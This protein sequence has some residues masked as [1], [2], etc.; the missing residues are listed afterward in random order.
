MLVYYNNNI[1][2]YLGGFIL[3]KKKA[4][5]VL[6]A[7]AIAASAFV[8]TAP[9]GADAAA[10][11]VQTLVK[12]AKDAGTVLKWAIS[13]E[14]SADGKTRPYAQY[15]AAKAARD[16]AVKAINKLPASQKA[17]YLADIEQN[18]TLHIN[19]TMAYIDAIT[20][21]EKITVKKQALEAQ[22]EKNLIDDATEKAYHELSTEIRKQAIL[23]DRVYGQSTRDEIRAQYKKSAEAVRDSVK[24]EVSVKIELDLAKKALAANNIADVEKHLAAAGEYMKEV[25]NEAMKAALTKALEEVEAQLTPAVK[26]VAALNAKQIEV[27][28]NS[29]L[30]AD[31]ALTGDATE[32]SLY[33]LDN[34]AATS[35]KLSDDKKSVILTFAAGIEGKDKVV[36][37]NP[38]LTTKKDKDGKFVETEKHSQIFTYTDEVKPEVTS[39]TYENGKIIVTY[40]EQIGTKPSVVRVNGT[41]VS[42]SDV[43]IAT[44]DSTKVEITYAGLQAGASASLYIAGTKDKATVANEAAL[45]NG[46]VVAPVAD[47]A[48]P[49]VTNVEVTGQNTA[50]ITLSKAIS[51]ASL[52]AKLQQGATQ[53]NVTLVKDTNDSTG[54][55]YTL[56]VDINGGTAGDG[57]FAGTSTTEAFVLYIAAN[58]MTDSS[59][60]ALK[61]DL[62]STNITFVKDTKAPA[63]VETKVSTDNKKL[64]F[65]FDE[66]LTVKGSTSAI[67]VKNSEGVKITDL[68]E[69][70]RKSDD[71]KTYQVDTKTGDVAL[72]PGTYTVTLPVGFFEDQYGNKTSEMTATF[73]VGAPNTA[74]TTKPT[75]S[76]STSGTNEF[77]L[78]YSE[79]VTSNA[80]NLAN[81]KLDGQALPVGTDI[82][83]TSS[84][85]TTVKI[86]LPENSI[87]IGDQSTGALA[88]LNISSVA[89]K[90]GNVLDTVNTSVTVKDNTSAKVT[91]VQFIGTDVYV[92]FNEAVAVPA[93]TNAADLFKVS[94]NGTDLTASG[95]TNVATVIGNTKQVKF[96]LKAAPAATPVVA[97]KAGQTTL[98]DANGVVVK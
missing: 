71:V 35:V 47:T 24:F 92:T 55:T 63:L 22:I 7:T 50:K 95:L 15:N 25:K 38:V 57:I 58:A 80:L 56:P 70:A 76:V 74:D 45:F 2:I 89:D 33:T 69:S 96:S 19:R 29:V 21:G 8:A 60:S 14:G 54:K 77:Q 93:T 66:A 46:T 39:T 44:A 27:K 97:V 9:A 31:T 53:H 86:V 49:A 36:V 75:V 65:T 85:K 61:N 17:G 12:K 43:A 13:T 87:N 62:F 6:S 51:E 98:K 42:T 30:N 37:V 84:A 91:N 20:A 32:T 18:V 83:F 90:A 72:E 16:A 28:F 41:P 52:A 3:N 40:S 78:V 94:V 73:T 81:Y 5:K 82:F 11:D 48:K 10:T 34:V 88:H 23:L 79:E 59:N 64:D 1:N 67:V 4:I 26:S 68:A